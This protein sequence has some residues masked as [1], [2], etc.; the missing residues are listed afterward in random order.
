MRRFLLDAAAVFFF[1]LLA[2]G[3][4]GVGYAAASGG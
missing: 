2:V 3:A 4:F 1:V